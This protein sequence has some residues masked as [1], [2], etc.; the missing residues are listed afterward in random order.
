MTTRTLQDLLR[1]QSTLQSRIQLA[2]A[3]EATK[4]RKMDLRK[5][6]LV[7]ACFINK[8]EL[9][10]TNDILL[11]ELDGF[12]SRKWDR[13]LFGLPIREEDR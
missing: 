4:K 5:K 3:R 1:K 12:L 8:H 11:Q 13:E 7:G 2:E 10:C 6:I 9:A